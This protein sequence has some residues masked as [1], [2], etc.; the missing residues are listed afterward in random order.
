M[1][2]VFAAKLLTRM[3]I[4]ILLFQTTHSLKSLA[5]VFFTTHKRTLVSLIVISQVSFEIVDPAKLL[6]TTF[7]VTLIIGVFA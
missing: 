1:V 6:S 3:S 5:A 2:A 4:V 7:D